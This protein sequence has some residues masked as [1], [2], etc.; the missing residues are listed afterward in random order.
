MRIT[1]SVCLLIDQIEPARLGTPHA[2]APNSSR[3]KK[4]FPS[5]QTRGRMSARR[6]QQGL[7][8]SNPSLSLRHAIHTTAM[9]PNAKPLYSA[10]ASLPQ[11]PVPDLAQTLSKYLRSTL[12][13][14][15][16]KESLVH[17][18]NAVKDAIAGK[19]EKIMRQLQERLVHRATAEGRESWL[20]DWWKTIGYTGYRDPLVPFVSYYYVHRQDP[21]VTKGTE[22]AA[23][24]LKGVLAFRELVVS[25]RLEPEKS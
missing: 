1:A 7:R 21:R 11:L 13:L 12:P 16:S 5:S 25:E 10:Q 6:I 23:Q 19:D 8:L 22:R 3:G 9:A 14:H 2:D 4:Q 20:Y 18:E 24:I 17:T 15:D